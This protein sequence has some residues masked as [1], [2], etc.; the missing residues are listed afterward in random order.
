MKCLIMFLVLA[1]A[2]CA[3]PLNERN[4]HNYADQGA[5]AQQAGDW[6]VARRCWA[7]VVVNAQLAGMT[8][9]EQAIAFYEY[10]R[11]CGVTCFYEKSEKYLLKALALD[12]ASGGPVHMS[13][14]ELARLNFDQGK[15]QIAN[16]YFGQLTA[17]YARA[18]AAE[19]DPAG[20][21]LVYEEFSKSLANVNKHDEAKKYRRMSEQLKRKARGRKSDTERTPYGKH[22]SKN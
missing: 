9:E 12:R 7:K 1:L 14:L 16:H 17:I 21:A 20:V 15:Y 3:S 8:D 2:G 18:R 19:K 13:L 5:A 11:S 4:A 6:D 22:C 10:G